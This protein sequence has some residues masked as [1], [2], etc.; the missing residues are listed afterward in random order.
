MM[1]NEPSVIS[2]AGEIID[3]GLDSDTIQKVGN[4]YSLTI[5]GQEPVKLGVGRDSA[6]KYLYEHRELIDQAKTQI[7]E[8]FF[9]KIQSDKDQDYSNQASQNED[10][11]DEVLSEDNE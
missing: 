6:K 10:Q 2:V 1:F 4:T 8:E 7:M 11:D 9:A 3:F 5:R